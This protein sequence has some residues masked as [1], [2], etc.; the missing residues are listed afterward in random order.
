MLLDLLSELGWLTHGVP[1]SKYTIC[2]SLEYDH[3]YR[4]RRSRHLAI[5]R[6]SRAPKDLLPHTH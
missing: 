3:S 6:D 1:H 2:R 4:V 5:H